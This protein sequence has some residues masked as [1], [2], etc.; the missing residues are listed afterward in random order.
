MNRDGAPPNV[1]HIRYKI[2]KG[3]AENGF[4]RTRPAVSICAKYSA[5]KGKRSLVEHNKRFTK[6]NAPPHLSTR[7]PTMN[8]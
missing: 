3:F 1:Q 8:P 6:G 5:D 2:P 7:M 4:D